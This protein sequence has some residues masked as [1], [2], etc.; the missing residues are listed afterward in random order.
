MIHILVK[1]VKYT[2][3]VIYT[4]ESLLQSTKQTIHKS[5]NQRLVKPA[6]KSLVNLMQP[7]LLK[8]SKHLRVL[9]STRCTQASLIMHHKAIL[10]VVRE[11]RPDRGPVAVRLCP[12][13]CLTRAIIQPG[14]WS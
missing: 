7:N 13:R 11:V 8:S 6:T 1:W 5:T 3:L 10:P 12:K 9:K 14:W 2:S 4:N